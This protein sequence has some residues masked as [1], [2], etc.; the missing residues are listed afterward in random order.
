LSQE[1]YQFLTN[2]DGVKV[3]A[4]STDNGKKI[5]ENYILTGKGINRTEGVEEKKYNLYSH[6][7]TAVQ[8]RN[9]KIR[10]K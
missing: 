6:Q 1:K 8:K 7:K 9:I 3:F 2:V 10:E 4:A 5:T